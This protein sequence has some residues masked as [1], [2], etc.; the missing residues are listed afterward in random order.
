MASQR[1]SSP[2]QG[3]SIDE[4]ASKDGELKQAR[5]RIEPEDRLDG[6]HPSD[7]AAS[8]SRSSASS[9]GAM[10]ASTCP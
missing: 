10:G 1:R 3:R 6:G 9:D 2:A 4:L 8:G 5:R 7:S